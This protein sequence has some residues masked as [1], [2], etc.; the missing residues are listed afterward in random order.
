M[1]VLMLLCCFLLIWMS[2]CVIVWIGCIVV[3]VVV[4]LGVVMFDLVLCEVIWGDCV[5]G[6]D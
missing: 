2:V 6:Y 3:F 1:I 4:G 5:V